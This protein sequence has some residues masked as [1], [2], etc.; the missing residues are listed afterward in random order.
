MN[1]IFGTALFVIEMIM[2]KI[3]I[4]SVY[5]VCLIILWWICCLTVDGVMWLQV[6]YSQCLG[7][8]GYSLLPLTV[9]AAFLPFVHSQ[10]IISFCFKVSLYM[11]CRFLVAKT[12][13]SDF[14][15]IFQESLYKFD[16]CYAVGSW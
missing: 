6:N 2:A 9:I 12:I 5:C 14:A 10:H 8:I 3:I 4:W 15:K 11:I 7:V 16:S 1:R 13:K